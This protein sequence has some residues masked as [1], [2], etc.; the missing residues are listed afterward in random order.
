MAY[1]AWDLTEAEE[2]DFAYAQSLRS[3]ELAD[4]LKCRIASAVR[5]WLR[6]NNVQLEDPMWA[7]FGSRSQECLETLICG[8]LNDCCDDIAGDFLGSV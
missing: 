5:E 1:S 8:R 6:A 2:A 3:T 7:S 4:D